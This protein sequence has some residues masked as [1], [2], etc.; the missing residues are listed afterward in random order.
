MGLARSMVQTKSLCAGAAL[1][2][3]E[4]NLTTLLQRTVFAQTK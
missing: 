2:R 3:Q 1:E 4:V